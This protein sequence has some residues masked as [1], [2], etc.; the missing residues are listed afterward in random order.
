MTYPQIPMYIPNPRNRRTRY[1]GRG[2]KRIIGLAGGATASLLGQNVLGQTI[3]AG[4][5][6]IGAKV[7]RAY[8]AQ[9]AITGTFKKVSNWRN[10]HY[11]KG[12]YARNRAK[13]ERREANLKNQKVSN[14]Q[15][16]GYFEKGA[17]TANSYY[18]MAYGKRKWYKNK[19]PYKYRKR[20]SIKRSGYQRRRANASQGLTKMRVTFKKLANIIVAAGSRGFSDGIQIEDLIQT[21]GAPNFADFTAY[22]N[23]WKE[24]RI[25]WVKVTYFHSMNTGD[26]KNLSYSIW[27]SKDQSPVGVPVNVDAYNAILNEP[28]VK[29][30]FLRGVGLGGG[31]PSIAVTKI[32]KPNTVT[33]KTSWFPTT[34]EWNATEDTLKCICVTDDLATF[35]S[36]WNQ[37]IFISAGV[38]FRTLDAK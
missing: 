6:L 16:A 33:A 24:Y 13:R 2:I 28:R 10:K 3:A 32:W 26:Y 1:L 8:G 5:G 17:K 23:L 4:A 25:N 7:A 36:A 15:P 37:H 31:A 20:Q 14:F 30:R 38:T 18:P 19:I 21:G 22:K 29:T 35:P 27:S 9:K 11:Y 12:V 34:G